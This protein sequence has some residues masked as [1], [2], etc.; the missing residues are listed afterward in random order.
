MAAVEHLDEV[1]LLRPEFECHVIGAREHSEVWDEAQLADNVVVRL[2]DNS[3][4]LVF[5]DVEEIEVAVLRTCDYNVV[6]GDGLDSYSV[7]VDLL[8]SVRHLEFFETDYFCIAVP[9]AGHKRVF[10]DLR[11][12]T[13]GCSMDGYFRGG[14]AFEI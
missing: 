8:E 5:R 2:R 12:G 4:F 1:A 14:V 7:F 9:P 10:V 13:E 3:D 11:Y 6:L